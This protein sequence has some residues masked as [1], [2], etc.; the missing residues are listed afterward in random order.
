MADNAVIMS[1]RLLEEKTAL[2]TSAEFIT[3]NEQYALQLEQFAKELYV[4]TS[5]WEG[6]NKLNY[7]FW[8]G[9]RKAN[10]FYNCLLVEI[11]L[12]DEHGRLVQQLFFETYEYLFFLDSF[13]RDDLFIK[14]MAEKYLPAFHK[15]MLTTKNRI[16]QMYFAPAEVRLKIQ[17]NVIHLWKYVEDLFQ[18]SI[19]DIEMC[20]CQTGVDFT[21]LRSNWETLVGK[22]LESINVYLPIFE[23]LKIIGKE[24]QHTQNLETLI[25][26]SAH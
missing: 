21:E 5:T 17:E 24:G 10:E 19:A 18:V 2:T 20:A 7:S 14:K 3:S 22:S 8:L 23:P 12:D 25:G 26:D 4:E 1:K 15:Q 16:E 11:S 6:D 13:L 9:R